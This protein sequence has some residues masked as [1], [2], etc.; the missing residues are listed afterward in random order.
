MRKWA[1]EARRITSLNSSPFRTYRYSQI[2][3]CLPIRMHE[4]II[5]VIVGGS[6]DDSHGHIPKDNIPKAVLA[7]SLRVSKIQSVAFL[8]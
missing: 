2:A 5:Y 4:G 3:A 8:D 1:P 6:S 7:L